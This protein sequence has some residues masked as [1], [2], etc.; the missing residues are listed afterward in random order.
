MAAETAA[1]P[2][3]APVTPAATAVT[4]A[5]ARATPVAAPATPATAASGFHRRAKLW[6]SEQ[7]RKK[8]RNDR[9]HWDRKWYRCR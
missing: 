6:R 8:R 7:S 3:A 5:T 1:A 4:P 2:A 9:R